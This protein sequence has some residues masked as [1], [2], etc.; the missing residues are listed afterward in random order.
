MTEA[1]AV[2]PPIQGAKGASKPYEASDTLKSTQRAEIVD[3]LGEGQI[4]GLVNGLKSV[5]LDGVPVENADGSRNFAEFGMQLTLGGPTSEADHGFGDIQNEV[6]VGVTVL[7]AVPV[8]RTVTDPA[9]DGVRVTL[10]WPQLMEAKSNG[11]RVG[12]EVEYAIDVQSSG[13][14]W[15]QRWTE[16]ISGKASQTYSR[17]VFVE[18]RGLGPAPWDVRVRRITPDSASM[19]LVNAFAWASYTLVSGVRLRYRNSAV[20]AL[21]FDARNFAAVPQRWYDLMGVSDWDVPVNYNPRAR[22]VTGSW[23]GL[24][25]QDWTNNPAWVLYNLIKH[26]RYGLGQYVNQLPDKWTLYQLQL[27]CDELVPDGRGGMEPRYTLNDWITTQMEALQLLSEICAVFRGVLMAGGPELSLTWDAPGTPVASYAP[28]NVVDG[29]F[30]YADGSSAARKTSCT[31]WYTDRAQAAKRMPIT[32]DDP[33]LVARYGLRTMEIRPR[34]VST[35]GQ[36]LRMAKWALYTSHYEEQTVTFRVG[37]EGPLRRLGEIFQITDPAEAGERLGGRLHGATLTTLTLD[38]PVTLAVGETYKVWVQVPHPTDTT[39]LV[40]ENRTVTTAAGATTTLTVAS[41]FSRLPVEQTVWLLEGSDVAPTLWRYVAI[42]ETK[43]EDGRPEYEVLGVRHEPGKFAL[44]EADQPLT[45]SPTRRLPSVVPAPGPITIDETIWYDAEGGAHSRVT[46]SWEAPAPGLWYIFGYRLDRG[47]WEFLSPTTAST[48]DFAD[49]QPGI[50]E[51]QVQAQDTLGRLSVPTFATATIVGDGTLPANVTGLAWEIKPGQVVVSWDRWDD[52]TYKSTELRVDGADWTTADFLWAGESS[53][54][55]HP[56]PPNGSY[57]VRARHRNARGLYSASDATVT[58]VVDDSIDSAAADSV[59]VEYSVNGLGSWHTTF[60]AGDEWARW[61]VGIAG[62]WTAAFRIVG[63]AGASGGWKEFRFRRAATKPATPTGDNPAGWYDAPPA[64]DGNPLWASLADKDA[65]GHV[66]GVWSDPVRIDGAD[67]DKTATV[68]IYQRKAT[69]PAKPSA[70]VTYTFATATPAGMNN[71]W[72]AAIPAGTDPL[73]V[74]VATALATAS[75]VADTIASGEWATPVVMAQDGVNTAALYIYRRTT[76]NSPPGKPSATATYTFSPPGLAGLN[77]GWTATVPGSGGAYLWVSTATALATGNTDTIAPSEWADPTLMAQDGAAGTGTQGAS[78]R[79]AYAL[80]SGNPSVTGSTIVRAGDVL[81]LSNSWSPTSSTA[82]TATTQTPASGQALFQSDGIYDPSANT[83]TWQVPYLSN[84]KVGNLAALSAEVDGTQSLSI[85]DPGSA[86]PAYTR[87]AALSVNG[88]LAANVGVYSRSNSATSPAMYGVNL[89]ASSGACGLYGYGPMGVRGYASASSGYGVRGEAN[90]GAGGAGVSGHGAGNSD[91]VL[92][93]WAGFGG[94]SGVAL[95]SLGST[96]LDGPTTV[97]GQ[98]TI[99]ASGVPPFVLTSAANVPNLNADLLDGY[100]AS[101]F[102]FALGY[103]PVQ[104][105]SGPSQTG[106]TVK[107][108]W[109]AGAM[110]RVAVDATDF[111]STWPIHIG[112][113]AAKLNATVSA[114]SAATTGSATANFPG[115]N[116]P[117]SATTVQ[118]I[119]W[120]HNGVAGYIPFWT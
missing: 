10:T 33:D 65:D 103:T 19:D 45:P 28:A 71:G 6:G 99:T 24:F 14:G 109:S 12:A 93:T 101:S 98:I 37:A 114:G 115:N 18:L 113:G 42:T 20:A 111:G 34:G 107:I 82:W 119:P 44:I 16:K 25:K 41:A 8:V 57:L 87:S 55:Q 64:A 90:G 61:K 94:S 120:T 31:C 54:Y 7:A 62:T 23:N 49:V 27:W 78:A 69:T 117:G 89:S 92:A 70:T 83:T 1:A 50:Y 3:L 112:G 47:N 68:Y 108:G 11:D 40:L 116:K 102:Q 59:F 48:L 97:T 60:T 72:S 52:P 21:T 46:V 81:P 73:W 26:P 36:A 17:A 85:P 67:G 106:N 15:V 77:N 5:Y 84:F 22:S 110:L 95:R 58:V 53:E 29:L 88:S 2:K 43:G 32:W 13:G 51:V 38:A 79:R 74:T 105:G 66:I 63:E 96:V 35:P 9:I 104:Q 80:F 4:G 39:R 100:H 76:S 75:A 56:R 91:G 30:T 86:S 118:W